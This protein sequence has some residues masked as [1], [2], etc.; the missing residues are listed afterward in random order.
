MDFATA[1]HAFSVWSVKGELDG[2]IEVVGNEKLL[3]FVADKPWVSGNYRVRIYSKLE[4]LAGNNLNK[5]FDRDLALETKSPSEQE[6][7]WMEFEVID[8]K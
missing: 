8:G 2:S 4:D 7:Y 5:L 1:K 3:K 6:F